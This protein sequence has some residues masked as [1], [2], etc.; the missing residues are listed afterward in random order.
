[1]LEL[2]RRTEFLLL[3]VIRSFAIYLFSVSHWSPN[4]FGPLTPLFVDIIHIL[5][6]KSLVLSKHLRSFD[7]LSGRCFGLGL[8]HTLSLLNSFDRIIFWR[9]VDDWLSFLLEDFVLLIF[10]FFE[11]S[12][13][14]SWG[15]SSLPEEFFFRGWRVW[16]SDW[17]YG[18]SIFLKEL[19][20]IEPS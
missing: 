13:K 12:S 20:S 10:S 9:C 8:L 17:V 14:I 18:A 19:S 1:M 15:S 2:L 16:F 5:I 7:A 6:I 4:F 3:M 11:N